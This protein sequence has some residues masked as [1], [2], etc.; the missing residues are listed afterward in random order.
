MLFTLTSAILTTL[1]YNTIQQ[2]SIFG[3][4]AI[5]YLHRSFRHTSM[6]LFPP[7][8]NV[9]CSLMS[10]AVIVSSLVSMHCVVTLNVE[11]PPKTH[12]STDPKMRQHGPRTTP[13]YAKMTKNFHCEIA[14]KDDTVCTHPRKRRTEGLEYRRKLVTVP[15]WIFG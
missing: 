10:K 14:C 9:A 3:N 15:L 6:A 8:V 1:Q 7:H 12:H 13:I 4:R 5:H 11:N 2:T